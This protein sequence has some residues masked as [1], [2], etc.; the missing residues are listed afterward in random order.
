MARTAKRKNLKEW[1]QQV[2]NRD[3]HCIACERTDHLNSHHILPKESYKEIMF[4][5]MNGV[6]LCPSHHKF[7]KYSAHKNPVWF[8]KLLKELCPEQWSWAEDHV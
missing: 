6:T 4:D 7:G 1:S 3:G 8:I 5:I 2:R